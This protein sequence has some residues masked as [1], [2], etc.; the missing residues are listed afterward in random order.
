MS[1]PKQPPTLSNPHP[2]AYPG[3]TIV[4]YDHDLGRLDLDRPTYR[5]IAVDRGD[6]VEFT[7]PDGRRGRI[8]SRST[9]T[10][11]TV[12][13]AVEYRACDWGPPERPIVQVTGYELADGSP[14]GWHDFPC[15]D[16]EIVT[17]PNR[18]ALDDIGDVH[19]Q[20]DGSWLITVSSPDSDD[21]AD[22]LLVDVRQCLPTGWEVA[23]TGNSNTDG[24]GDTVDYILAWPPAELL[25]AD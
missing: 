3:L 13:S 5:S 12:V 16:V 20:E 11:P 22:S 10:P 7:L 18:A 24:S 1:R 2:T 8:P 19:E 17:S 6:T 9:D 4:G 21:A 14:P 15:L 25:T 23:W